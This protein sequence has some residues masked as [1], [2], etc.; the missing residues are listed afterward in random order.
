[1]KGTEVT[2]P[3]CGARKLLGHT[4]PECGKKGSAILKVEDNSIWRI[5]H[6][7]SEHRNFDDALKA[8]GELF[9]AGMEE[10]FRIDDDPG[11]DGNWPG[12][13]RR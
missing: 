9:D 5:W 4:C 2:C 7:I 8:A 3:F 10:D 13:L 12:A 6:P 1:M 11:P